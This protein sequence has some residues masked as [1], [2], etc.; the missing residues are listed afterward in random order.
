MNKWV[1]SPKISDPKDPKM[2]SCDSMSLHSPK[3]NP[4]K[5]HLD[6]NQVQI[7]SDLIEEESAGTFDLSL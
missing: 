3:A 2:K 6:C 4:S 1:I 5:W 7:L